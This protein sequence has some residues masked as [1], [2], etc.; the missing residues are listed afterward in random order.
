MA[1]PTP[2]A[3]RYRAVSAPPGAGGPGPGGERRGTAAGR[4][5]SR[6]RCTPPT[7]PAAP[8][9]L[10]AGTRTPHIY[11]LWRGPTAAE[12]RGESAGG[13]SRL[14][15]TQPVLCKSPPVGPAATLS[16]AQRSAPPGSALVPAGLVPGPPPS[17]HPRAAP[18]GLAQLSGSVVLLLCYSQTPFALSSLRKRPR[19]LLRC[20]ALT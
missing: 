20:S 11:T 13:G 1:S 12:P 14:L 8:R 3:G 4:A 18:V 6:R 17:A 5:L 10:P 19:P 2:P 15:L 9:R 7:P 16:S